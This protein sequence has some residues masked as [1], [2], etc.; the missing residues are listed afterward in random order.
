MEYTL[1]LWYEGECL[2]TRTQDVPWILP[3]EGEHLRI[4]FRNE[5]YTQSYGA[6][7]IVSKRRFLFHAAPHKAETVQLE[8][9]I[10]SDLE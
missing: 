3:N 6:N 2:E 9:V 5:A 4:I 10:D 7:W 1:E 8:C